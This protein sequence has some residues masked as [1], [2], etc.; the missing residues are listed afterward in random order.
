MARKTFD[1]AENNKNKNASY[2][3]S[4]EYHFV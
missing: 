3:A 4:D 1:A 2:K